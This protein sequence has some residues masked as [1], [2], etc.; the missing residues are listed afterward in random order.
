MALELRGNVCAVEWHPTDPHLLAVGSAL[1][2]ALVYDT[3][4]P[5]A[6]LHTLLVSQVH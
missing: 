2:C 1:H 3:R 4:R 6:P 5:A